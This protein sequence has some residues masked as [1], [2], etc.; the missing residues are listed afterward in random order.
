M[1]GGHIFKR[2]FTKYA[3][4]IIAVYSCQSETYND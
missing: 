3:N 4:T 1:T 2:K